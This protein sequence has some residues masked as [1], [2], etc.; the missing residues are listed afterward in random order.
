[1]P[2]IKSF[3]KI[4]REAPPFTTLLVCS[5]S[6]SKCFA[7]KG[8]NVFGT[9]YM[10]VLGVIDIANVMYRSITIK[11]YIYLQFLSRV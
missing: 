5:D 3:P 1:M 6:N 7:S 9:W 2:N 10:D 11:L 4:Y 8:N